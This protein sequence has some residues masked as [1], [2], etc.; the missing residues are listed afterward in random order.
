MIGARS[1]NR[2]NLLKGLAAGVLVAATPIKYISEPAYRWVEK[3]V[4]FDTIVSETLQQRMP[5]MVANVTRNNQILALLQKRIIN[6]KADI[7][8]QLDEDLYN[9]PP[10]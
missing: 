3:S 6:T 9:G 4:S 7:Q 5:E 10:Y 8:R 2:R 1:V